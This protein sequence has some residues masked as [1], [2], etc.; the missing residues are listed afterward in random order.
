M[1]DSNLN[2]LD[3]DAMLKEVMVEKIE[4]QRNQYKRAIKSAVISTEIAQEVVDKAQKRVEK[5]QTKLDA[6]VDGGME[7]FLSKQAEICEEEE[8]LCT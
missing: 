2:A 5:N 8:G 1:N 3:G 6:L 4:A 7:G